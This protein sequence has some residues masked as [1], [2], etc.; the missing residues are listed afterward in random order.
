[1]TVWVLMSFLI[2]SRPFMVDDFEFSTQ[3]GCLLALN[4]MG[5]AVDTMQVRCVQKQ[6]S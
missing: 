6:K 1:M 5:P 4:K 3:A 2:A